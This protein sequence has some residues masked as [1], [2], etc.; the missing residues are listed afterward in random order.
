MRL[1]AAAQLVGLHTRD[2]LDDAGID[3]CLALPPKQCGLA[4]ARYRPQPRRPVHPI[5]AAKRFADAPSP[6]Y[7]RGM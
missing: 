1:W 4:D 5:A 7:I 3:E 6:E 2:A